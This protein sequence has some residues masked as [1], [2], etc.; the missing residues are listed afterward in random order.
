MTD[1]GR[2]SVDREK[3]K[4]GDV[5]H[6]NMALAYPGYKLEYDAVILWNSFN[7]QPLITKVGEY[8]PHWASY[9]EIESIIGHIDLNKAVKWDG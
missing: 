1:R 8:R 2:G 6:I 7:N 9:S 5:V 3:P 4:T